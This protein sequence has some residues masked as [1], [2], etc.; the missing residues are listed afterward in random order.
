MLIDVSVSAGRSYDDNGICV[1]VGSSED[2]IQKPILE[3]HKRC[4]C[5][6]DLCNN[7]EVGA[8]NTPVLTVFE[9]ENRGYGLKTEQNIKRGQFVCEYLG[10]YISKITAVSRTAENSTDST[11]IITVNEFYGSTKNQCFIDARHFGNLARFINHSC[12]P[13]LSGV[14]VRV[15]VNYPRLALFASCDIEAGQELTFSYGSSECSLSSRPCFC[16]S[17]KCLGFLPHDTY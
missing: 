7:H 1:T 15:G 13:N 4:K 9:T 6:K 16:G 10:E 14:I 17:P 3:C 2:E 5:D 12:D 11:Y 8:A